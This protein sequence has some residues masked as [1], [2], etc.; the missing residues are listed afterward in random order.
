MLTLRRFFTAPD[1][2]VHK[3]YTFVRIKA[4]TL[5]TIQTSGCQ[6]GALCQVSFSGILIPPKCSTDL[7]VGYVTKDPKDTTKSVWMH[8]VLG[9]YNFDSNA[10]TDA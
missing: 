3:V 8:P 9:T 1:V 10:K 6:S 7:N 4:V 5:Q 2:F